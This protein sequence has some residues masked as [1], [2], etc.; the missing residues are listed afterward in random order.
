MGGGGRHVSPREGLCTLFSAPSPGPSPESGLECE[1][2]FR[3]NT[4]MSRMKDEWIKS[5]S[6]FVFTVSGEDKRHLAGE[7]RWDSW[8][9]RHLSQSCR[10]EILS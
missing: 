9:S 4:L 8:R 1:F 2:K 10:V 7:V 6:K 3:M 5:I